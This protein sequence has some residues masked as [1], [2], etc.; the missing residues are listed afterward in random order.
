MFIGVWV[1]CVG[2]SWF[3]KIREGGMM[4]DVDNEECLEALT[5]LHEADASEKCIIAE[6]NDHHV[7]FFDAV[8]DGE[9]VLLEASVSPD[10]RS[11]NSGPDKT[12]AGRVENI[13]EFSDDWG[14][15][16]VSD[17]IPIALK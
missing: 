6:G 7:V 8:T 12:M 14:D 3:D 13:F 9:L 1:V 2:M 17:E 4:W 10:W 15:I 5:E 11:L 16:Y